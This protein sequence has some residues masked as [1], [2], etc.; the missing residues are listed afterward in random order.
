MIEDDLKK[1]T[2]QGGRDHKWGCEGGGGSGRV[3]NSLTKT[4]FFA[5]IVTIKKNFFWCVFCPVQG[6]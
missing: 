5:L 4:L 1:V 2:V 3:H 6:L